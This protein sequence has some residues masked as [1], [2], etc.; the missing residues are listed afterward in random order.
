MIKDIRG[1]SRLRMYLKV[2]RLIILVRIGI[3]TPMTIVM[4]WS[5]YCLGLLRKVWVSRISARIIKP[6]E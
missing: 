1:G 6:S 2:A 5:M 4:D 3:K